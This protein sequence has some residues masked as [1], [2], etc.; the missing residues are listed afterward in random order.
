M[1]QIYLEISWHCQSSNHYI[2]QSLLSI[3]AC[4]FNISDSSN[5]YHIL[6]KSMIHKKSFSQFLKKGRE[7]T[8]NEFIPAICKKVLMDL[9]ITFKVKVSCFFFK[10]W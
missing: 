10:D 8:F 5:Y 4:T 6:F 3:F 9:H 2:S 7:L 1:L